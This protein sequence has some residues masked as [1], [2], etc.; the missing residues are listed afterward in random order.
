MTNSHPIVEEIDSSS[1][2]PGILAISFA[3]TVL[4]G[5]RRTLEEFAGAIDSAEAGPIVEEECPVQKL[6]ATVAGFFH[7]TVQH[8]RRGLNSFFR[9]RS[10]KIVGMKP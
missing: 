8:Q 7:D 3:T 10:T 2:I 4:R 1:T 9:K 5:L 6:D